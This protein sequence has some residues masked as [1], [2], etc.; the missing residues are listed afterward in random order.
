MSYIANYTNSYDIRGHE[1]EVTAPARFDDQTHQV[2][3]DLE[4]DDQAAKLALQK[5]PNPL[6]HIPQALL[7]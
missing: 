1:I 2:I 6:Y 3:P 5:V 4:L 7:V